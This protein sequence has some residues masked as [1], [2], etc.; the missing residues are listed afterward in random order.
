MGFFPAQEASPTFGGHPH[1]SS[2]HAY[3]EDGAHERSRDQG[4]RVLA[5]RRQKLSR[6]GHDGIAG[7]PAHHDLALGVGST[8]GPPSPPKNRPRRD[9]RLR[10]TYD[11]R[12]VPGGTMLAVEAAPPAAEDGFDGAAMKAGWSASVA[13]STPRGERREC[14]YG[15]G[16]RQRVD[17][18]RRHAPQSER[19]AR[20]TVRS[21]VV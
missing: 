21:T 2:H 12:G 20:R 17:D 1:P 8:W 18:G 7:I 6:D 13:A 11:H 14:R 9:E 10:D 16:D 4:G 19:S 3:V 15:R 5:S